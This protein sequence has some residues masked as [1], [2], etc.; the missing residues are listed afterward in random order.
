[1]RYD[2]PDEVLH[3]EEIISKALYLLQHN[4]VEEAKTLLEKENKKIDEFYK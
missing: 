1:M 4:K 2:R 3:L